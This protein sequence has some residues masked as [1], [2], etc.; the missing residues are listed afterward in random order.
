MKG[1]TMKEGKF[2]FVLAFIVAVVT[3]ASTIWAVRVYSIEGMLKGVITWFS[4]ANLICA[5]VNLMD[6]KANKD[7]DSR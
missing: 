3:F 4:L 6:I 7:K 5:S 1:D 2:F